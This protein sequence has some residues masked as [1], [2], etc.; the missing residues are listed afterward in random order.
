MEISVRELARKK[1]L[2]LLDVREQWERDICRIPG[3]IHIPMRELPLRLKDLPKGREIVVYCHTGNRSLRASA[4][5]VKHG[6]RAKS[7]KG[8]IDEW[9]GKIDKKMKRY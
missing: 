5:L 1:G 9:A 6:F 3:D 4:F 8:G 2:I 7:L